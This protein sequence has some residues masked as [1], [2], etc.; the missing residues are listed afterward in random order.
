MPNFFCA[1]P[2]PKVKAAADFVEDEQRAVLVSEI[3]DAFQET[4]RGRTKAD[5]LHDD[6]SKLSGVIVEQFLQGIEIVVDE[7]MSQRAHGAGNARISRR[8]ADIPILPAMVAAAGNAIAAGK[9]A[10]SANRSRSGIGPILAEAHLLGT[11]NNPH[12]ALGQFHL[13]RMRQGEAV[14][15]SQLLGDGLIHFF[16][17]VT[18]NVRQQ[19]LDVI[20]V[21][22]AIHVPNAAAFALCEEH[23]SNPAD[24]LVGSFAESLRRTRDNL[25]GAFKPGF[26]FFNRPPGRGRGL[27][28]LE[29]A[30]VISAVGNDVGIHLLQ[31]GML[32]SKSRTSFIPNPPY[33][34]APDTR[35]G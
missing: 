23:G 32:S 22:V 24:V 3:F 20:D 19:S 31:L 5:R 8:A 29:E 26:R 6:R 21:L 28:I 1:P 2:S 33:R 12:K 9:R 35:R 7:G 30:F 10:R 14:A 11:R 15:L 34:A 25:G 13:E 17:R 18:E 27:R 4:G 16:M